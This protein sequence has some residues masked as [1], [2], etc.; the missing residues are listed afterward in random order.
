MSVVVQ[1]FFRAATVIMQELYMQGID[2]PNVR[3]VIHYDPP[4]SL[5]GYSQESGR[6]GRD[7]AQSLSIMYCSKD[8]LEQVCHFASVNWENYTRH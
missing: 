6:A 2:K 4:S 5:E 1:V 7:G 8:D 3:W